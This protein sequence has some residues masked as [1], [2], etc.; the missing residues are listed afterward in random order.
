M[1]ANNTLSIC[2]LCLK[3]ASCASTKIGHCSDRRN[4]FDTS[5]PCLYTSRYL[6]LRS[7]MTAVIARVW[8]SVSKRNDQG[9][10]IN[11]P[12]KG[13]C[14]CSGA[15]DVC[16]ESG[17]LPRGPGSRSSVPDLSLSCAGPHTCN[18]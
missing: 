6:G 11:W 2:W 10:E 14:I 1:Q 5:H 17:S 12:S 3:I 18:V 15:L 16:T 7:K 4:D 8:S 13:P 9:F